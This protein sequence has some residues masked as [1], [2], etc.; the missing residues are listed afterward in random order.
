MKTQYPLHPTYVLKLIEHID[1]ERT[2][3]PC[4]FGA[5]VKW[6]GCVEYKNKTYIPTDKT[7]LRE[8]D[9]MPMAEYECGNRIWLALDGSIEEE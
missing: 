9:V 2:K 8:S 3:Y 7:A 4:F 1:N 6:P 5:H